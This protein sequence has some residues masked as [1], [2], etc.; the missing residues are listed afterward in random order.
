MEMSMEPKAEAVTKEV[1][2]ELVVSQEVAIAYQEDVLA[3]RNVDS[4]TVALCS[5]ATW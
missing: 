4:T 2:L 3:E 5:S 1:L